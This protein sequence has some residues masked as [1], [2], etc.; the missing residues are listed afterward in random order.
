M[1]NEEPSADP[2]TPQPLF[3]AAELLG[4]GRPALRCFKDLANLARKVVRAE[5]FLD[6]SRSRAENSKVND[7][8][9]RV[10][11]HVKHL[12]ARAKALQPLD[13]LAPLHPGHDYIGQYQVYGSVVPFRELDGIRGVSRFHNRVAFYL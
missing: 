6:K 12:H 5:R 9:L 10:G 8:V 13:Q 11:R 3:S 7:G 4:T 2:L 1:V